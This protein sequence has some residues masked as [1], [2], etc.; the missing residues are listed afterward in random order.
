MQNGGNYRW[1]KGC[2]QRH[3]SRAEKVE[4]ECPTP[5]DLSKRP[6]SCNV[7]PKTRTSPT[8][9][10]VPSR[11]EGS[12]ARSRENCTH[13]RT[14]CKVGFQLNLNRFQK[15]RWPEPRYRFL[16]AKSYLLM[17]RLISKI[18]KAHCWTLWWISHLDP[19]LPVLGAGAQSL[20]R[21]LTK[22]LH[23]MAKKKKKAHCFFQYY[24]S[25][26]H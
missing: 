6:C 3:R 22:I 24:N 4:N 10:T 16:L 21:E 7:M 5:E 20:V 25:F 19:V 23:R 17:F 15:D 1:H 9:Y 13:Q 8:N 14:G 18:K 26:G 11:L 12:M 2:A